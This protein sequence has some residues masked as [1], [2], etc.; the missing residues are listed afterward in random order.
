[1]NS[2]RKSD[3]LPAPDGPV[4]KWN[5]PGRKWKLTLERTSGPESYLSATLLSRITGGVAFDSWCCGKAVPKTVA[6][7]GDQSARIVAGSWGERPPGEESSIWPE[8]GPV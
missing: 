1:M 5:E 7:Q 8:R 6:R 2:S 3:V 4:K